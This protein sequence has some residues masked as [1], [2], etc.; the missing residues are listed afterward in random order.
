MHQDY[1][2]YL[3]KVNHCSNYLET[4]ERKGQAAEN[5]VGRIRGW[6]QGGSCESYRESRFL[7]KQPTL[8]LESLSITLWGIFVSDIQ[9]NTMCI[10]LILNLEEKIISTKEMIDLEAGG[11]FVNYKFAV[12]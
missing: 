8:I 11:E 12:Q 4:R 5:L 1:Q 3:D 7:K 2:A 10:L 9:T 6:R